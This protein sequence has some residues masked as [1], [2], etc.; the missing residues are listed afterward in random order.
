MN[1]LDRFGSILQLAG[2]VAGAISV[3]GPVRV[4][5]LV[6]WV[7]KRW[8]TSG[9]INR[10]ATLTRKLMS[11]I[12]ISFIAGRFQTSFGRGKSLAVFR[13]WRIPIRVGVVALTV[14]LMVWIWQ[15][16]GPDSNLVWRI[17][18]SVYGGTLGSWIIFA[19]AV[20]LVA[21]FAS[22]TTTIAVLVGGS[23]AAILRQKYI[24]GTV[25]T[26]SVV[27]VSIGLFLQ[28]IG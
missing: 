20:L 23:I 2:V 16:L 8:S 3:A 14:P 18:A 4:S 1:D 26:L 19:I 28:I 10:A 24:Y 27:L 9:V 13:G 12:W 5:R 6:E 17:V 25:L 11:E 15:V 21:L 7:D 22:L